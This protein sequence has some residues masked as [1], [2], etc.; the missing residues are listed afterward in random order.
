MKLPHPLPGYPIGPIGADGVNYGTSEAHEARLG[1]GRYAVDLPAPHDTPIRAPAHCA[2]E[3]AGDDGAQARGLWRRLRWRT[4]EGPVTY[5]YGHLSTRTPGYVAGYPLAP[6]EV[7]AYVDTTGAAE[8]PHLHFKL[9]VDGVS[10][11]PEDW[12]DFD[13]MDSLIRDPV[14][15]GDDEMLTYDERFALKDHL[16]LISACLNQLHEVEM[17]LPRPPGLTTG[18]QGLERV[19]AIRTVLAKYGL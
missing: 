7:F 15:E 1:P 3:A 13:Q 12:I 9:T 18:Q 10:V 8:G 5:E 16:G 6:G 2:V 19:T 17:L 14:G 4:T 11:R